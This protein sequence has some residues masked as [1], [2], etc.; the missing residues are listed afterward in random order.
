MNRHICYLGNA[1]TFHVLRWANYFAEH[2]WKVDLISWRLPIKGIEIHRGIKIHYVFF[3]PHY[4]A[5]YG[6]LLEIARMIRNIRPDII[7][8]HYLSHFGIL[9]ALYSSLFRFRPLV[10]TAWGSD[11]LKDIKGWRGWSIRQLVKFAV[12]TADCTTCDAEHIIEVLLELGVAKEKIELIYFGTDTQKFRP[13]PKNQKLLA[14]LDISGSPIVISLRILRPVYD[15]ESLVRSVPL[16][17]KEV[18]DVKFIIAGD[19]GQ[20]KYLENLARELGIAT[21]TRFVGMIANDE[22]PQYLAASDIYVSTSLS[23]AGLAASTAEAMACGLPMIITDFGDN[24]KWVENDV[25]GFVIPLKN[26]EALASKIIY[27]LQHK[28]KRQEFGQAG[29]RIIEERNKWDKEMGKMEQIYN[30][31]IEKY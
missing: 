5:R 11:V 16:V 10:L 25:N 14:K 1:A 19:G 21:S 17:L 28:G 20:R 8:A 4:I 22:L 12:R 9:G 18:P 6:T 2:G 24:R 15:I 30:E 27:L 3:P 31:L 26:P 13:E 29:R 7:H 23:D